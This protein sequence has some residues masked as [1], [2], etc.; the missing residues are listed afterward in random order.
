M[1][2]YGEDKKIG[3]GQSESGRVSVPRPVSRLA[4]TYVSH[5][6]KLRWMFRRFFLL[7]PGAGV[8]GGI[9]LWETEHSLTK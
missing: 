1:I 4:A 5:L 6:S 2:G 8:V 3:L 7:V 9:A